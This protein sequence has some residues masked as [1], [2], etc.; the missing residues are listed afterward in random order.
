MDYAFVNNIGQFIPKM[1]LRWFILL[2]ES[3]RR[4]IETFY[5]HF[6]LLL[7]Y[8]YLFI[9]FVSIAL[10][11]VS[12]SNYRRTIWKFFNK[13]SLQILS[14]IFLIAL[15]T[16]FLKLNLPNVGNVVIRF[17]FLVRTM[18]SMM[19]GP[20]IG[21]GFAIL[22]EISSFLIRPNAPLAIGS[23]LNSA[24]SAMALG[25][26]LCDKE[27]SFWRIMFARFVVSV[28]FNFLFTSIALSLYLDSNLITWL[29]FRFSK[30]IFLFPF[31]AAACY[32]FAV[33]GNKI[34]D[35]D[36]K[37]IYRFGSKIIE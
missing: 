27:F 13:K 4:V 19:F 37:S 12:V 30:N 15:V 20:I 18:V 32:L 17:N 14:I 21:G 16:N 9:I 6:K 23:I 31:E 24:N 3:S 11:Y 22:C 28:I 7:K 29:P 8:G 26:L 33:L 25:I 1:F 35:G 2:E 34:L 10:L 36:K 5:S